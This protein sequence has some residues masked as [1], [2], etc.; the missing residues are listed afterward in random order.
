MS[1]ILSI[2]ERA[3]LEILRS[4]EILDSEPEIEYDDI[5][6]LASKIC[7][8]PISSITLV[9]EERVWVKSK[10]GFDDYVDARE[11]SFC[12]LA[13]TKPSEVVVVPNIKNNPEFNEMGLVNGFEDGGF[14]ASV[15]L[16][17]PS[18]Y[19]LGVLC[20]AGHEPKEMSED[21]IKGLKILG[22]KVCKLLEMRKHN[23]ALD[24]NNQLLTLK[25]NEL[26][27]FANVVSHDI[28]SPLNNIISLIMLLR[29]KDQDRFNGEEKIYLDYLTKSSYQL[30][31]YVDALLLYYKSGEFHPKNDKIVLSELLE[32]IITLVDPNHDHVFE[33][34]DQSFVITTNAVA[35]EQILINLI[36]NGI[37]Y[38]KQSFAKITVTCKETDN[39]VIISVK[40]NGTGIEAENLDKIFNIFS[41]LKKKDRF[42]N[43]G[44]GIGLATVKKI[45]ESL[46]G[47]IQV[48]SVI[49]EG[50]EFT[51]SFDK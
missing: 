44:T 3:R 45:T 41:T 19:T 29:E 18:G 48:H 23:Q 42:G 49:N 30:K 5:T 15:A 33:I 32:K 22:G 9:D 34:P 35:L 20:V 6:F 1:L 7:N 24:Q 51:L 4:Y 43:Y 37:K 14:Y 47:K 12:S 25:Y 8:A 10:V 13:I 46:N 39:Q 26:E 16:K 36:S 11:T 38:N 27:Q 50:S 17:D 31:D 21:Q 40:D 2:D 28:K